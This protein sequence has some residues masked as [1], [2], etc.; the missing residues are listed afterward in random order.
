MQVTMSDA[1]DAVA[2]QLAPEQLVSALFADAGLRVYG[3][4]LGSRMGDLPIAWRRP[5]ASTFIA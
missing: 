5:T 1:A 4:V 3:M 2:A